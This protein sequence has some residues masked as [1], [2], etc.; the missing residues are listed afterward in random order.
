M[1]G[2]DTTPC[3]WA[4]SARCTTGRSGTVINGPQGYIEGMVGMTDRRRS[5]SPPLKSENGRSIEGKPS[6][7]NGLCLCVLPSRCE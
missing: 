7:A 5:V 1:S 4:R 2:R 3:N 6:I